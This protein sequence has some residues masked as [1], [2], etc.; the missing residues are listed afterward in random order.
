MELDHPQ[1]VLVNFFMLN[2]DFGKVIIWRTQYLSKMNDICS[3]II[4]LNM[5]ASPKSNGRCWA[6]RTIENTK[7]IIL[8]IN[9]EQGV[10]KKDLTVWQVETRPPPQKY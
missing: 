4:S 6:C 5:K 2:E 8:A 9:A 7:S 3:K 10:L 1:K